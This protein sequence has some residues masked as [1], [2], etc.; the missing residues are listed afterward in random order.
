MRRSLSF[1][2]IFTTYFLGAA[3]CSG[4][5]G[6]ETTLG[7][8][9]AGG[10][11]GQGGGSVF[12][13]EC[14]STEEIGAFIVQHEPDYSVVSGEVLDGIVPSKI[15]FEVGKEGDC[16][17]WQRKNPFCDPSCKPGETC[18]QSG[19][20]VPYPLPKSVGSVAVTGLAKA[21]TMAS[22]PYFDTEMPHPAFTPGAAITLEAQGADYPGFTLYGQGFAPIAIPKETWMLAKGQPLT[23]NW[24]PDTSAEFATVRVKINIDQHGNSPVELVCDIKDTGS[25]TIPVT[26]IDQL[27][28]FGVTGFPSGHVIRHTLD[29]ATVGPGCVRFEV[30]SHVIGDLQ[31][32]GHVPCDAATP[33]PMGMV[34]DIPNGTCL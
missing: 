6:S 32:A 30:F 26:L 11:G 14:A 17:L 4:G 20:C 28:G 34:C 13:G 3:A 22:Q 21:V 12:R 16:T 1:Q 8:G 24:T 9:G 18:D 29:K 2:F 27:V 10:A 7:G 15:L 25:V 31:V 5:D 19:A 23:L 33:C